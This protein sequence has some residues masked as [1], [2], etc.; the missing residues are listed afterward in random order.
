MT[1]IIRQLIIEVGDLKERIT[2]L[3]AKLAETGLPVQDKNVPR[4]LKLEGESY[5]T[6]GGL[7]TEGYHICSIAFGQPRQEDCIFCIAFLE[8]E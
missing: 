6:L 2:H 3:E 8:K 5:E 7:Y 1:S 4:N